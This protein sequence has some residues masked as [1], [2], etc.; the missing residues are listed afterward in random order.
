MNRLTASAPALGSLQPLSYRV[1]L[2]EVF[3][4]GTPTE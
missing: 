3:V 1:G 2:V 4:G